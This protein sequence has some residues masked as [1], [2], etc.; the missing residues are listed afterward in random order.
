MAIRNIKLEGL[1]E[2]Q[3]KTGW[4]FLA[5]PEMDDVLETLGKRIDRQGKG[6]GAQ[7][8]PHL[9]QMRT[10][11]GLKVESSL[12]KPRTKGTAWGK[13]NARVLPAVG[14]NAMR[15]AVGRI[16]ARWGA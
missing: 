5:Q 7:R 12:N 14:R 11:D 1:E 6:L 8:N 3:K 4:D 9:N 16:E 15:K 13:K 2:L 10:A